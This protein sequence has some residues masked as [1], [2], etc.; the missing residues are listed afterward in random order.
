VWTSLR[1]VVARAGGS[2]EA[3][4][5]ALEERQITARA[6]G[7]SDGRPAGPIKAY[8]W[9]KDAKCRIDAASN[10]ARFVFVQAIDDSTYEILAFGIEILGAEA[11]W[12][13]AKQP[14]KLVSGKPGP[15]EYDFWP[16]LFQHLELVVASR[17]KRFASISE[18]AREG[19]KWLE[20]HPKLPQADPDTV[21][22]KIKETRPDLV[23][24]LIG[25]E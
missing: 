9:S 13:E 11:L 16:A 18:A 10:R 21:R 15:K 12:P 1:D 4:R 19:L 3:V 20:G 23:G 24:E 7:F 14:T 17:G 25:P 5:L 6:E 22:A 2:D 8:W